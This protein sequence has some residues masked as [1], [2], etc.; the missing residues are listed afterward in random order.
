VLST[1]IAKIIYKEKK[2]VALTGAGISVKSGIPPFRSAGG[3][4]KKYDPAVYASIEV[5]RSDPSKYWELR[6]EF[7]RNYDTYRP[8]EAHYALATLEKRG[9]LKS[10]I[11][12]NI[13]GLHTKAGSRKVIELHG[14]LRDI[15]CL[16]CG[17]SYTAPR[18]PKGL[19]PKCECGGI[20]KPN[21]VLFGESLPQEALRE[22]QEEALN[23][24]IMMVIATSGVVQPAASLPHYAK[25][26]GAQVIEI[27]I[28]RALPSADFFIQR[29]AEM[30]LPE[31][32]EELQK[33]I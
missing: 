5:F 20:L 18:V 30:V 2:T 10:V 1:K 11:T 3:V 12:Q 15:L 25:R 19:P 26:S 9:L 32:I 16:S 24:R 23:C 29:K 31:I 6:G 33:L 22:A 8:N 4:W 28:E 27:N 7:I 13:D 14:S 21:T 17:N